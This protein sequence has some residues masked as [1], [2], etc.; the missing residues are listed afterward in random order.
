MEVRAAAGLQG[1]H[2]AGAEARGGLQ[3]GAGRAEAAGH[4]GQHRG[5]PLHNQVAGGL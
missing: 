4:R 1:R 2:G 5:V 3:A